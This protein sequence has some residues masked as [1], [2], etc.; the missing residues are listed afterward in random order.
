[1]VNEKFFVDANNATDEDI[2]RGLELLGKEKE[3]KHKIETGQIKGEKKWA[4][5]T[6]DE[7]EKARQQGKRYNVRIKLYVEKAK[8][9]GITVTD[10][11]VEEY[12][13]APVKG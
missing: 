13:T 1:M 11:E 5:L 6:E 2:Q 9:A 8:E 12:L 7:K 4:E 3:R 10:D